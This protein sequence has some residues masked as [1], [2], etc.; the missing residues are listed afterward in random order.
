MTSIK[1]VF[2]KENFTMR[3]L[4]Y[5]LVLCL[6]MAVVAHAGIPITVENFSF[7]APYVPDEAS[8]PLNWET[9]P[10]WN[11]DTVAADSG[12][13]IYDTW[14]PTEGHQ[15][16]YINNGDPSVWNLTDHVIAAGEEFVLKIDAENT[17][18][19]TGVP[20]LFKVSLYYLDGG[21]RVTAAEDTFT[22]LTTGWQG[23]KPPA[24]MECTVSFAADDVPGSIG[25]QLGIELE[26]VTDGVTSYTCFD[27]VR[28]PEPATMVLLSI[29]GLALLRRR[30]A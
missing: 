11:S 12:P 28:V 29:G 16:G 15:V 26:D 13:E 8:K 10:G 27:N 24:Y 3:N 25:K 19:P 18:T 4:I 17:Y 30:R 7:E 23:G 21:N 22:M 1:H 9:T 5:G 14:D 6:S 20:S 2:I